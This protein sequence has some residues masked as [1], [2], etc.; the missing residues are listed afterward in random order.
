MGHLKVFDGWRC[1]LCGHLSSCLWVGSTYY[2]WDVR[3]PDRWSGLKN[4]APAGLVV[5]A[6]P[7]TSFWSRCDLATVGPAFKPGTKHDEGNTSRV[8]AAHPHP[9]GG[10]AALAFVSPPPETA[11]TSL[12][13]YPA[14]TNGAGLEHP[15]HGWVVARTTTLPIHSNRPKDVPMAKGLL[16]KAGIVAAR[17]HQRP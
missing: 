8:V 3:Y 17:R 9:W 4:A 13:I 11:I 16:L 14:V 6:F 12:T 7:S 5:R 10:K 2:G 15:L 1:G